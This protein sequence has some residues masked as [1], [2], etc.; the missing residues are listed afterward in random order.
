MISLVAINHV[1][2]V[3]AFAL[4]CIIQMCD[5]DVKL[6][7]NKNTMKSTSISIK[8]SNEL[9]LPIESHNFYTKLNTL[10]TVFQWVFQSSRFFKS[11][12]AIHHCFY[13]FFVETIYYKCLLFFMHT[14]PSFLCPSSSLPIS[15]AHEMEVLMSTS[16]QQLPSWSCHRW[17]AWSQSRGFRASPFKGS[18][19]PAAPWIPPLSISLCPSMLF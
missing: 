10:V 11:F 2:V 3:I 13:Y 4:K 1:H 12:I 7:L 9:D 17:L 19:L 18:Y 6:T 15:V 8:R 16:Y 5:T 14:P